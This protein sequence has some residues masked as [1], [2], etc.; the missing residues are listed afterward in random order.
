MS[1]S[2]GEVKQTFP[3]FSAYT[4]PQI[5]FWLDLATSQVNPNVFAEKTDS[6]VRVLTAHYLDLAGRGGAAG[7]VTSERVGGL[8]RSYGT[9]SAEASEL[10]STSYGSIFLSILRTLPVTPR[11]VGCL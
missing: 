11:V 3:E 6:A 8:S 1:V 10:A 2:V 9:V 5:Q 7:P 4:N